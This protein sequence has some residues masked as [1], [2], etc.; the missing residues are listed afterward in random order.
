MTYVWARK[1]HNDI[2]D[3]YFRKTANINGKSKTVVAIYLVRGDDILKLVMQ[4]KGVP[5]DFELISFPFGLMATIADVDS[6]IHFM[7]IV[8]EVTGS[9]VMAKSILAY[10]CGRSEEPLS[11]NAMMEWSER[12]IPPLF[13]EHIPSVYN[14]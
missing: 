9:T 6:E 11:N 10:L 2:T 4:K 1:N 7:D 14:T 5:D 3:Y 13:M 8:N 12:S